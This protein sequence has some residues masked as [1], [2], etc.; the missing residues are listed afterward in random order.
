[1]RVSV[2]DVTTIVVSKRVNFHPVHG[3]GSD[4]FWGPYV[5]PVR[6]SDE[7]VSNRKFFHVSSDFCQHPPRIT[8]L[9]PIIIQ[10]D[11]A[12]WPVK[13]ALVTKHLRLLLRLAVATNLTFILNIF[14]L[15]S[16]ENRCHQL[17]FLSLKYIKII[18]L[19]CR[20]PPEPRWGSFTALPDSL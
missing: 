12:F 11:E 8:H 4:H 10:A 17:W 3:S 9:M 6:R 20:A 15:H 18:M 14:L 5:H 1:M 13:V 19:A 16:D 2:R 7:K